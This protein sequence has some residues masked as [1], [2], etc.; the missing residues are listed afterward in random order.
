MPQPDDLATLAADLCDLSES[1]RQFVLE[2][3]TAFERTQVDVLIEQE[4]LRRRIQERDP[5]GA[6]HFSPWLAK[7]IQ[8]GQSAKPDVRGSTAA[9][10]KLLASLAAA[11]S[12]NALP[13]T[14]DDVLPTRR[15]SLLSTVGGMLASGRGQ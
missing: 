2:A 1:Q 15:K 9:T 14:P 11:A 13:F 3:L 5:G 12:A 7:R 4:E 10:R 6:R 8:Q